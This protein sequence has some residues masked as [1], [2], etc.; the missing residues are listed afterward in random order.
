VTASPAAPTAADATALT[1]R[2]FVIFAL[3]AAAKRAEPGWRDRLLVDAEAV[4]AQWRTGD[5]IGVAC[6]A[7]GIVGIDL[8]VKH[9]GLDRFAAVCARHGRP[10][11]ATFTVTTPTG[12][13]H[14]YFR[15]PPGRTIPSYSGANSPL[16]LG[17]DVRAPGRRL[18]A[19]LA[20]PGSVTGHGAYRI[21]HDVPVMPLPRWLTESLTGNARRRATAIPPGP[22]R[23]RRE[24][25]QQ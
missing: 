22:V 9:H 20:G 2:G 24:E 8:D 12:G 18:G 23:D 13:Q 11:P 15:T 7:S 21:L 17:V 3:P 6:R 16:G 10:R 1:D 19:Y 5:N 14:L 25:G 4:R